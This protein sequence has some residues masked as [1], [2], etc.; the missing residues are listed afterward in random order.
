MSPSGAYTFRKSERLC[1]KRQIA[2]LYASKCRMMVY[3]L[4]VH[5]I[6]TE[7]NGTQAACLRATA[8]RLQVLIVA[9]KK[10]LHH[11]VDRNRMKRLMRECYRVR[12]QALEQILEDNN[13]SM[14]LAINYMHSELSDYEHLGKRF[15]KMFSALCDTLRK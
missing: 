6:I 5:W 15:D 12:K 7:C 4:S 14:T 8:S 3:P 10:K 1:N 2:E 13:Q 9:P 11:A